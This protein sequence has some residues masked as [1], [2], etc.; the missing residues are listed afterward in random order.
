MELDLSEN[1]LHFDDIDYL[2]NV[3]K[4][5]FSSNNLET[6]D[7]RPNTLPNLQVLDLS[8]NFLVP[9]ALVRI[10]AF[11]RLKD[12]SLVGNKLD[13]I[14]E[15]LTTLTSL[16]VLNISHN[17][18]S[19]DNGAA[20]VWRTLADI[21]GL[22]SLA[23]SGNGLR[24]IHTE[25]L[26]PGD[27][28]NLEDLDFRENKVD[29]QLRLICARNFIRLKR[30]WVTGND[31]CNYPYDYLK[32]ELDKRVGAEVAPTLTLDN[33]R[34]RELQTPARPAQEKAHSDYF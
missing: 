31:F 33:K 3:N 27:F 4:L 18:F 32:D 20:R 17:L 26:V 5:N 28:G 7:I 1:R 21:R 10:K 23:L 25:H 15:E 12:L 9:D 11:T 19:S 8:F 2:L 30:L 13:R 34:N 22:R 29:D 16:E 6:P 14:P 24:G